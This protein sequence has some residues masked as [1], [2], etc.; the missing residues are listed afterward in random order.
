MSAV[1]RRIA[2]DG[3]K[4]A[5][6]LVNSTLATEWLERNESNRPLRRDRIERYARDMAAGR[7]TVN[8]DAI[9][10]AS[11]GTLQNGQH[12]L[13]AIIRSGVN[14]LMPVMFNVDPSA[15]VN[16]DS[17]AP[18]SASDALHLLGEPQA[19]TVAAIARLVILVCDGR[20]YQDSHVQGITSH[21]EIVAFV[22]E[23][24]EIRRSALAARA[25]TKHVP[26]PASILGAA[27]WL[28]AGVNGT[29]LADQYLSQLASRENEPSG[30]AIHAVVRRLENI[31]RERLHRPPRN[32]LYLLLT[33]WNY[34]AADRRVQTLTDYPRSVPGQKVQFRL[35]PVCR[36]NRA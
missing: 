27:H 20:I 10:I 25:A 3:L 13:H 24:P 31:R 36:W 30:S 35:P 26:A 29:S 19:K 28:I 22:E 18:R 2:P 33:G 17:G 1:A 34:Y 9:C 12:R 32:T 7:W 14:V 11:D 15:R 5:L 23:H 8:G 16:M 6:V 4:V 21:S